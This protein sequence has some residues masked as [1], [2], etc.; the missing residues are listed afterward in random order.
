MEGGEDGGDDLGVQDCGGD[1]FGSEDD[2]VALSVSLGED[3]GDSDGLCEDGGGGQ[4]RVSHCR[5]G[6]GHLPPLRHCPHQGLHQSGVEGRVSLE[7]PDGGGQE[8][9]L[10]LHH[11]GAERD[12]LGAGRSQEVQVTQLAGLRHR[13]HLGPQLVV[14]EPSLA[15]RE[16]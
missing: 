14:V 7:E 2:P 8:V 6:A 16:W 4:E 10:R 1:G 3:S 11:G 12:H 15:Q 13:D 5:Q 9:R